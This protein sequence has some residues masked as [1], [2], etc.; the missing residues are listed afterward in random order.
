MRWEIRGGRSP[1][2]ISQRGPD[3]NGSNFGGFP[4]L[5]MFPHLASRFGGGTD[6][7]GLLNLQN[8]F[9]LSLA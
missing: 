1:E 3:Q 8:T 4:P 7:G 9:M 2:R 6:Y 5:A